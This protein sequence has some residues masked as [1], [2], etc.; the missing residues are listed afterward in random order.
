[1]ASTEGSMGAYDGRPNAARSNDA[2]PVVRGDARTGAGRRQPGH[3]GLAAFS[4]CG[5][6]AGAVGLRVLHVTHEWTWRRSPRQ[7]PGRHGPAATPAATGTGDPG[8]Y[9]ARGGQSCTAH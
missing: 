3:H 7:Q 9:A 5:R 8:V 6:A 2:F 1:M 4:V